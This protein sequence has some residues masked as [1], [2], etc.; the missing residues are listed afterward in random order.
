MASL[1]D[2]RTDQNLRHTLSDGGRF[3]RPS[4]SRVR[5]AAIEGLRLRPSRRR[6][7]TGHLDFLFMGYDTSSPLGRVATEQAMEIAATYDHTAMHAE[8]ARVAS[9]DCFEEI[10][11]LRKTLATAGRSDAL[12]NLR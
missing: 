1:M 8:M 4:A 7:K 9:D 12:D 5:A 10:A 6:F 11:G 3:N 2:S